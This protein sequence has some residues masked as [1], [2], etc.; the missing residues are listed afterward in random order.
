MRNVRIYKDEIRTH[1]LRSLFFT[2]T[3]IVIAGSIIISGG[4]YLLFQYGL[5]IS[6]VGYYISSVIV[7]IVF[8]IA[9][10]TQR[11]DNQPIYKIFPRATAYKS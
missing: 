7:S 3:A 1:I 10:V 2:D 5:H 8:F 11:V 4:L 6:N 9:F